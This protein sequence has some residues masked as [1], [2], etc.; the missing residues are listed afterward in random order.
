[1]K[2]ALSHYEIL[3]QLGRGG[4]ATVYEAV[5]ID[6][7]R[8]VALKVLLPQFSADKVTRTRFLREAEAGMKLEH[9]GIVKVYEVAEVKNESFIAMELIEGKTLDEVMEGKVLDVER[10]IDIGLKVADALTAAHEKGIIHRDI[11]PQNIMVS[12]GSV[13]VT[14]FGLVQIAEASRITSIHE[15]VG[16]LH[17]MSPQQATGMEIDE[18][19]DLFSL[20]V[21]L[22]QLLTGT[23]PFEG[24][25]PGAII[26]SILYSDPLRMDE[27]REGIP[28]EVEQV[29]FK[30]LQ[31]RPRDRYRSAM[32]L[33]SDLERVREILKGKVIELIA[34]EQVFEERAGGVYS[35]LVGRE[36]EM[37][38]LEHRLE[39]M[40][41]GKGTTVLVKGEAGIGKSRLVWELGRKAKK[42]K[43]RYV[44]GRCL[45]G[46]EGF[47]YEPILE[48]VRSYLKLKG[49]KEP[50]ALRG[51][52]ERTARHLNDRM[53][54]MQ[55]LVFMQGEKEASL[56][57]KEQLWDTT[58]ELVKVMSQDRPIVLHLDDLH[59]ADVPTLNLLTYLSRNT[60]G[61]RIL[62]LGTYRPE[63]LS[64]EPEPHPLLAVLERM[65]KEQ[66]YEEIS[67]QR[68]DEKATRSVISSVFPQLRVP[69]NFADA[70][71]HDTEGNPL[72]I[73]ELLKLVRDQGVVHQE[74][75]E[76]RLTRDI[77]EVS[78][79]SR[80]NEVIMN[81]LRSLNREEK[82][83][84]EVA[85][86]EGRSFRS[87]T[88]RHCLGLPRIKVL[89]GLQDLE[90][91]HYLI[92]A[93]DRE[94]R[95]DHGKIRQVVYD[96]LIPELRRE[97]HR[98]IGEYFE[99]NHGEEE[100]YAGKI[101]HHLVQADEPKE[102]LPYL[103]RAGEHV[104]KLFANEEAIAY[105][106]QGIRLVDTYLK[107]ESTQD[108]QRTKLT[109]LRGKAGV[110][111]LVGS[112][113]EAGAAYEAIAALAAGLGDHVEHAA[114]L[115]GLGTTYSA[116]GDYDRALDY[117]EQAL[118]I[119]KE[120][121]DKHGEG[122][123]LK[124]VGTVHWHRGRPDL[125]LTHYENALKIH[126]QTGDRR[127]ESVALIGIGSVHS[128]RGDYPAALSHYEQ[129]LK[130][131]REIGDKRGEAAALNNIGIVHSA[132]GDNAGALDYYEQALKIQKRIGDKQGEG[133]TLSN[134]GIA[135]W[136]SGEYAR[137]LSRYEQA[138]K[139]QEEIGDRWGKG[140]S[141]SMIG[142]IHETRGEYEL[143]LASYEHA[144]SA[145][146]QIGD[147]KG[148]GEALKNL[149]GVHSICGN[150][151]AAFSH[152]EQALRIQEEIGDTE[153][154]L[155]SIRYLCKFWWHVGDHQKLLDNLEE[156]QRIGSTIGRGAR[157]ISALIDSGFAKFLRGSH[158][159]ALV[160][161]QE[162][163][164]MAREM[165][166]TEAILEALTV[167][168]RLELAR[169]NN[170]KASQYAEEALRLASEKGKKPEAAE[171]HLL[172][173]GVHLSEGKLR[174][175]EFEC[176]Q[177]V[178]IAEGCGMKEQ[179]W[180][181][182]HYLGKISLARKD[183]S[184]AQ[185]HLRKA[186]QLVD[187][188]LSTLTE[189]MA[190]TYRGKTEVKTLYEDLRSVNNQ[191]RKT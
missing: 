185:L 62:I 30:A 114:A 100:E 20:G 116:R 52:I 97:Y 129:A 93:S 131:Q 80:V 139:I 179:L 85:S 138:L 6:T 23:L 150:Y 78:I 92:H 102:A 7:R 16:T 84:V 156:A 99:E 24:D 12:N 70:I 11:K 151:A 9:P 146:R 103:I 187:A 33:K 98:L 171:T 118:K 155:N 109:L 74:N 161:I 87:D 180:H 136:Y 112:Y 147:K 168:T 31:K 166:D 190:K 134:I 72:F 177:A 49:V 125:A 54:I 123:T 27:L 83:L 47:P 143:A 182:H 105:F 165:E 160:D 4:M 142:L 117:L 159:D 63:E 46:E 172:L 81:R 106:D 43:A 28:L 152:L 178:K 120:T 65:G 71:Y 126:E 61:E 67:L 175:A 79:P 144:L 1:M 17:Y 140:S 170:P 189:D 186:V 176:S 59:W 153:E 119:Q 169:N 113:D 14:D 128:I 110:K 121:G 174:E 48:V 141:L 135:Y 137:A 55:I 89:L 133:A 149:G 22:Y 90:H 51:F 44:V 154:R 107:E 132:D 157:R 191:S 39:N 108:L 8:H 2:K 57:S 45:L 124:N 10:V 173:A 5:D 184:S 75:G 96:N 60:R 122:A 86:V 104:K 188:M 19:S 183:S 77:A 13:K 64:E 91:S 50:G 115:S 3:R 15:I 38:I 37:R 25:H 69:E 68:L 148:V 158:G 40:L 94:Y 111:I 42:K 66:L 21:V 35:P 167:A 163:L 82:N 181:A 26:H 34:T 32:E 29:V 58:T 18:R 41:K 145:K 53:G 101:A 162:A 36:R 164:R 88:L 95:F 127:G 76:W 130:I 73:L 56:V